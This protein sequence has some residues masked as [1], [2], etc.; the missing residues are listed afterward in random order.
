MKIFCTARMMMPG[1]SEDM[2]KSACDF[3]DLYV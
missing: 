2:L 3:S 1:M